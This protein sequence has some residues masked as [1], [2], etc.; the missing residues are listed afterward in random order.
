M[1]IDWQLVI[2]D[3]YPENL[4]DFEDV[5]FNGTLQ[6]AE[7]VVREN[8]RE[9][10]VKEY[11]ADGF[12]TTVDA[13]ITVNV[14]EDEWT[15]GVRLFGGEPDPIDTWKLAVRQSRTKREASK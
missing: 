4:A 9:W 2:S 6:E 15:E 13:Y 12:M 10:L 1:N 11:N 7:E 3:S 14:S 8:I 5:D